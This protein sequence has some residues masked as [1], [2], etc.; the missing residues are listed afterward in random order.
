VKHSGGEREREVCASEGREGRIDQTSAFSGSQPRA[1]NLDGPHLGQFA[2]EGVS[3]KGLDALQ[4]LVLD[5]YI[6]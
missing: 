5:P 2:D 4:C 3:C 6:S 1:L